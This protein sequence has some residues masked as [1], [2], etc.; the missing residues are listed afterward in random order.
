MTD[1]S[2]DEVVDVATTAIARINAVYKERDALREE[3]ECLHVEV[4]RMHDMLDLQ[5][6]GHPL[7]CITSEPNSTTQFCQWCVDKAE[8]RRLYS[9]LRQWKDESEREGDDDLDAEGA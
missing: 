8:I 2:V 3:N 9:L 4:A 5:P 6:C 1:K 7:G